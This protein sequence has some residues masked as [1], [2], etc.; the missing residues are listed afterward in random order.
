MTK[1]SPVNVLVLRTPDLAPLTPRIRSCPSSTVNLP[2]LPP[3]KENR[4]H[5]VWSKS[6]LLKSSPHS[7]TAG[8]AD[9][10]GDCV[11]DAAGPSCASE[12][13]AANP[14]TNKNKNKRAQ[15]NITTPLNIDLRLLSFTPWLQRLCENYQ[16]NRRE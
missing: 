13:D 15:L 5:F 14:K 9:D 12:T 11:G 1:W 16:A 6:L 7:S 2:P 4:S 10:F 8:V 3:S